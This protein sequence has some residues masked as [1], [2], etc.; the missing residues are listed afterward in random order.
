MDGEK[1]SE[2]LFFDLRA[3]FSMQKKSLSACNEPE[4]KIRRIE[5]HLQP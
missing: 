5:G 1:P 4:K 2:G 3:A